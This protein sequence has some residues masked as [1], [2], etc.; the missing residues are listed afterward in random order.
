[1]PDE[2]P[3]MVAISP[4]GPTTQSGRAEVA[5]APVAAPVVPVAV[6]VDDPTVVASA[7]AAEVAADTV[8][9]VLPAGVAAA[10]LTAAAWAATPSALTVF[11][12]G[13]NGLSTEALAEEA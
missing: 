5:A 3:K 7:G 2:F 9:A 1:M 4:L 8:E 6:V 11:G 10:W 13:E 12:G